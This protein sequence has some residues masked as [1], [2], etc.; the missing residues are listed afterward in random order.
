MANFGSMAKPFHA[1]RAAHGGLIAARLA[2][3]GMT[4]SPDS[5]EHP[6][7]L[8]SACSPNGRVDL[9]RPVQAGV[10]WHLL[11]QGLS[12]KKYPTCLS[13][14]RTLDGLIALAETHDLAP[15]QV[16]SVRISMS[17]RNATILRSHR[18]KTG[19]EAKFSAEFA[20]AAA[21][22]R[23]RLTL[24]ELDN[25][26]V[27][28]ADVQALL[29]RVSLTHDGREDP[30]TGYA[31]YDEIVVC[32]RDGRELATRVSAIRGSAAL[33]LTGEELF[34][35]L[36]GCLNA[37]GSRAPARAFF[38]TLADIERIE[39]MAAFVKTWADKF[40]RREEQA[41]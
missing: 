22:L 19:L 14:H 3:A 23:R 20:V 5:L 40:G 24:A 8:L 7:G 17:G 2:Q 39:D 16:A 11:R 30:V 25:A 21:L 9:A 32:L 6:Q 13:T 41:T 15:E 4:A 26:F 35:K 36:S 34:E 38:D 29:P 33:P 28:G 18:P 31:P 10:G 27:A 37:A 1:G 12:I